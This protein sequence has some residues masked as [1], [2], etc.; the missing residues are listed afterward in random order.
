[1]RPL[2]SLRSRS[3]DA[4]AI[5]AACGTFFTVCVLGL[6]GAAPALADQYRQVGRVALKTFA[7][8]FAYQLTPRT[9]ALGVDA[10]E[11]NDVY[12]AEEAPEVVNKKTGE[13]EPSG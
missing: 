1:M 12:V 5:V 9:A 4:A 8:T 7:K 3:H 13:K 2:G 10:E 6:A 11:G